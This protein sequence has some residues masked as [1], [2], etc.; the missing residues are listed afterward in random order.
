MPYSKSV[1]ISL[2]ILAVIA[3]FYVLVVGKAF[4]VPLAVAV[5]IWYVINAL[6][7]SYAKLIPGI[8]S[9]NMLTTGASLISI[10]LF[11]YFAVSMVQ[12]NINGVAEAAPQYKE[13]FNAL[14]NKLATRFNVE[15]L[16]NLKQLTSSIEIA[17]VISTLALSL[18]HI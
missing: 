17:P 16:P 13:N 4:L 15:N 12:D 14:T 6:S 5:M 3:S 10:G 1:S 11:V 18:I 8:S 9:P 7:R 2:I